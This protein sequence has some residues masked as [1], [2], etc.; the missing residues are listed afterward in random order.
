MFRRVLNEPTG[1]WAEEHY[2]F[3]AG[4]AE[5][6]KGTT[7]YEAYRIV[8]FVMV[9]DSR[10]DIVVDAGFSF[11]L[12]LTG[13]FVRSLVIGENVLD[14]LDAIQKKVRTRFLAPAQGA[15]LQAVRSAFDRYREGKVQKQ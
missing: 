5:L 1:P 7:A 8:S 12:P 9:V 15:L 6:P 10:T 3:A 14:G 11:A 13:E 4:F 2:V